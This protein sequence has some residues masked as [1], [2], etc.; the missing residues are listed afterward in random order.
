MDIAACVNGRDCAGDSTL[1]FQ[2]LLQSEGCLLH[3]QRLVLYSLVVM[4]TQVRGGR[5]LGKSA[6]AHLCSAG[7]ASDKQQAGPTAQLDHR[8]PCS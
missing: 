4:D 1:S 5:S 8:E 7:R 2:S 6:A 3:V